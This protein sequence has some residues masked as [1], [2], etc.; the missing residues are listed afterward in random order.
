MYQAT[1]PLTIETTP[2]LSLTYYLDNFNRLVEHVQTLYPDLLSDDECR[3]LSEYKRLSIASQCLMVR[4]L[5]R[6]GCWFRSD[7]L[8]YVEIPD[9]DTALREL[10]SSRFITLSHPTDK[11]DLEV[12]QIE[13]GLNLLTKP[14]LLNVFPSLKSNKSAKKDQLLALLEPQ[15]FDQFQNLS[16]D[17]IYVVESQV[18]DVLLL[19]FFANT[20][21]DLSQFVLSDLGLDTFENYPLSKQ[22]RFFTSREQINQLFQMREIQH[23]YY[24]GDRKDPEFIERLLQAI[25]EESE[26]RSIARKRSRLINDLARDLERLNQNDQ[27]A[28]WFK[29]SVLPP[30]RERL[31]RIYDKQDELDLMCDIVTNIKTNPSD[32]SELEVAVKLEQ[33]LLRKQG[34]KVPRPSKPSCAQIKLELDLSQTRVELAVKQHFESQGWDVYFS[35]NSF[36][37]GLFGLAFWDV[38][39]SDVEG[40]FINRYQHRPLDL[41]HSDFIDKRAEQIEA[42]FQ[43]LSENGLSHLFDTYDN[44]QGIANPFVHWNHFPKALI[45]HSMASIPNVLIVELFKVILSDLKLFRTGMPD[46]I[47][48]K[49]DEFHWI[50]V[51]GPGDKLQDNQWRWIKEFERLSVP[52]SV[53]YVN[54]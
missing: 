34:H 19:L 37:C 2:Q 32:V 36:L 39:F 8:T 22:R 42:V 38:I 35:E 17:C 14:E 50:E 3:W 11:H 20:Y 21:Q 53:C 48:F 13:L 15:A 46:L 26:H 52:F 44:K 10:N 9:I 23:Q 49:D 31:A 54:Q 12:T 47:A 40:A 24:E 18:I 5:S 16:F 7:K 27:A 1:S 25:P 41:Y 43:T 28:F 4:L 6:K 29:Q 51:K 30:S 45:E 33:R